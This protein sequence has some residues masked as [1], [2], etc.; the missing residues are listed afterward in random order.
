MSS[1]AELRVRILVFLALA[2]SPNTWP[3][4]P[5]FAPGPHVLFKNG[6]EVNLTGDFG[7]GNGA[8]QPVGRSLSLKYGIHQNWSV[9][10]QLPWVRKE[11]LWDKQR[12]SLIS[13]FRFWRRDGLGEQESAA[14]IAATTVGNSEQKNTTMVGLAWGHESLKWYQWASIRHTRTS[15]ENISQRLWM[16]DVAIGYRPNS[17]DYWQPDWVWMLEMNGEISEDGKAPNQLFLSPG[18]MWTWRNFAIKTGIQWPI[19]I[20][21]QAHVTNDKRARLELEWHF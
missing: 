11:H 1:S 3:H 20:S 19:D 4:D 12:A 15:E 16:A 6:V 14:V 10:I 7:I 5:V 2:A 21:S 9:G 17:L 8:T 18:L 13:K